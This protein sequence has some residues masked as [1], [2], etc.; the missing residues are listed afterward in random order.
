[1]N[2]N[3]VQEIQDGM[4]AASKAERLAALERLHILLRD[5]VVDSSFLSS[6]RPLLSAEDPVERRMASWAVGKMAQNKVRGEYPLIRL[7]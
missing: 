7:I 4:R 3:D 6:L 5:K 1:M 2:R